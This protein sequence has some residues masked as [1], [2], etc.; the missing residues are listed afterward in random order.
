LFGNHYT[1]GWTLQAYLYTPR[2]CPQKGDWNE[3]VDRF[4]LL[5]ISIQKLILQKLHGKIILWSLQNYILYI[6]SAKLCQY[7]KWLPVIICVLIITRMDK[8]T[9]STHIISMR[10]EKK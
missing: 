8:I 5:P 6:D 3:F 10:D 2:P 9:T 1:Y 4:K 7:K